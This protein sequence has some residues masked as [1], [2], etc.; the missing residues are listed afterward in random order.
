MAAACA[1]RVR[2]ETAA[3]VPRHPRALPYW[4]VAA[5][6]S[7]DRLAAAALILDLGPLPD[8]DVLPRRGIRETGWRPLHTAD[9]IVV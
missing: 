2:A 8:A 9:D 4:K 6:R 3:A 7:E 5:S 1:R